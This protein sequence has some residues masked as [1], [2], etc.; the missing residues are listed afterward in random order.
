MDEIPCLFMFMYVLMH[1]CTCLCVFMF[2]YVSTCACVCLRVWQRGPAVCS[3][4]LSCT[5]QAIVAAGT[6]QATASL[7]FYSRV[8]VW[9]VCVCPVAVSPP[10]IMQEQLAM[11]LTPACPLQ[12]DP[13]VKPA[14]AVA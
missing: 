14:K 8:C 11:L 13:A 12:L 1:V 2:T 9:C 4:P 10:C 5:P 3:A 7:T 6:Q